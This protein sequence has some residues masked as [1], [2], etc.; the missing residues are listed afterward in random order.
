MSSLCDANQSGEIWKQLRTVG[1]MEVEKREQGSTSEI[2]Y[3]GTGN[4]NKFPERNIV[5]RINH[6]FTGKNKLNSFSVAIYADDII[7][8]VLRFREQTDPSFVEF[9]RNYLARPLLVEEKQI[10]RMQKPR[11]R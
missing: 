11:R 5:R 10:L 6:S 2:F 1:C 7:G 9:K 4:Q 8:N 3:D